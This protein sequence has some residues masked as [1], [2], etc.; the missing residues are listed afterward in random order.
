VRVCRAAHP[1]R[2]KTTHRIL[3]FLHFTPPE[4]LF[5]HTLTKRF[6]GAK[7]KYV[8]EENEN[9]RYTCIVEKRSRRE[10]QL[11]MSRIENTEK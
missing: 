4:N 9:K 11:L 6:K 5:L 10:L 2:L 7:G 8:K 3:Y 1:E